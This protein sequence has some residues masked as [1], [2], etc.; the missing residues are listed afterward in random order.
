MEKGE[1]HKLFTPSGCLTEEALF[2][3]SRGLLQ[4]AELQHA[5]NHIQTCE[6]CALALEGYALTTPDSFSE[7]MNWL[8]Q[9]FAENNQI[10]G[11]PFRA[12]DAGVKVGDKTPVGKGRKSFLMR[13]RIELIAATLLLLIAIGGRQ[14]YLGLKNPRSSE[15]QTALAV[16][17]DSV[18][19]VVV[20]SDLKPASSEKKD[21]QAEN[22]PGPQHSIAGE[23][24]LT[25][26]V[27]KDLIVADDVEISDQSIIENTLSNSETTGNAPEI[28]S[29]KVAEL[30]DIQYI[31]GVTTT[32]K[33][34][35]AIRLSR[36]ADKEEMAEAEIFTVV[37][38]TPHFP[39]GEDARIKF[40]KENLTYPA[41]ARESSIQ[42]IVFLT[43]VIEKDGTI[44]DIRVLRGI[45]GGC[46]EEAVRVLKLMPKWIPGKQRGKPVRVQFNLPVKFSLAG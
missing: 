28:E 21:N 10:S 2:R 4:A 3:H 14:V 25:E 31:E 38:E 26:S 23:S 8:N 37:E 29:S 5:D 13:Y 42:G 40:L 18:E 6:L 20:E 24:K 39:G 27:N 16:K 15:N 36:E 19:K 11:I 1:S 41:L 12:A 33:A 34:N 30:P 7:D 46:D 22:K 32:S 45:G 44:T 35:K 9:K 43:L 17:T